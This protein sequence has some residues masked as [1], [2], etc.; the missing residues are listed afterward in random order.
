MPAA[1]DHTASG[2]NRLNSFDK[3]TRGLP[4]DLKVVE[5]PDLKHL[6]AI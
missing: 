2:C 1:F 4:H 5:D 6:V 3:T